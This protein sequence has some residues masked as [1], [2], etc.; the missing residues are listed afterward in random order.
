MI[1]IIIPA[2][3]LVKKINPRFFYKK[4][5]CLDDTINSI[6]KNIDVKYELILVIN[7]Y[8]NKELINYVASNK[9]INKFCINSS[10]AGVA[11][12]WNIGAHLAEGNFLCFCNDDVEF[13]KPAVFSKL[14]SIFDTDTNVGEVGPQGGRWHKDQSGERT[15]LEKISEA[16]EISGYFF[17]IPSKVFHDTGGFD[18]YYTPAGC[19]EIDMSFKIRSLGYKCLV[20][21]DTGII[22]HG[23]HG[24]SNKKIVLKYFDKEID[25]VELDKRNKKYFVKK[26]YEQHNGVL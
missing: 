9:Y 1:S 24:I 26:W 15:G 22:H 3:S 12:S 4:L 8:S 23:G 20:V 25:T 2:N 18:N 7:D 14:I 19:E 6:V 11:R 5:F 13:S 21:P 16:D 10:N 17:I